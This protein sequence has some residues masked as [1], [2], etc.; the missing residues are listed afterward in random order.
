MNSDSEE[1][2]IIENREFAPEV[3]LA[4]GRPYPLDYASHDHVYYGMFNAGTSFQDKNAGN[5]DI[6][7]NNDEGDSTTEDIDSIGPAIIGLSSTL[8]DCPPERIKTYAIILTFDD[9]DKRFIELKNEE[10]KLLKKL[11]INAA[12]ITE[13]DPKDFLTDKKTFEID[14]K[15]WTK[16]FAMFR[17]KLE[18]WLKTIDDCCAEVLIIVNSHANK[19]GMLKFKKAKDV[20][21]WTPIPKESETIEVKPRDKTVKKAGK[22][23]QGMNNNFS[24][25]FLTQMIAETFKKMDKSCIPVAL[26][27]HSCYS[28]V[29]ESTAQNLTANRTA[30]ATHPNLHVYASSSSDEK[31]YGRVNGKSY[32][33]P[34]ID[35]IA[36]CFVKAKSDE[37]RTLTAQWDC[38]VKETKKR[39]SAIDG[40]QTPTKYPSK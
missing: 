14:P 12:N 20:K 29:F 23:G 31:S 21:S 17:S 7:E 25:G 22:P 19:D 1:M 34:F 26:I 2:Q 39:A 16:S 35:A 38:I 24:S 28:G 6:P 37:T 3:V 18:A 11:G 4:D 8:K 15:T 30:V 10:K 36:H 27:N 13:L 33:F 5:G 9:T 32:R 40:L